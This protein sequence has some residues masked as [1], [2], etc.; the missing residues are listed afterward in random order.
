MP[1]R[2]KIF[3]DRVFLDVPVAFCRGVH[4]KKIRASLLFLGF[5]P[6]STDTIKQLASDPLPG[7]KSFTFSYNTIEVDVFHSLSFLISSHL[8]PARKK[9]FFSFLPSSRERNSCLKCTRETRFRRQKI[10]YLIFK[11]HYNYKRVKKKKRAGKLTAKVFKSGPENCEVAGMFEK[12]HISWKLRLINAT[13]FQ[14]LVWLLGWLVWL[15]STLAPVDLKG[16]S[17]KAIFSRRTFNW[18]HI[19]VKL[20]SV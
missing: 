1:H 20:C 13:I 12:K 10:I 17:W 14:T 19:L 5:S 9:L 7:R 6:K 4:G 18:R 15:M 3:R 2:R 8:M 16:K 11:L